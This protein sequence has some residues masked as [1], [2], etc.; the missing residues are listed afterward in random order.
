MITK[1]KN[2]SPNKATVRLSA[3]RTDDQP[4]GEFVK[5]GTTV[6]LSVDHSPEDIAKIQVE[7][8]RCISNGWLEEV[9]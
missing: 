4:G 2:I 1:I 5:H 9:Q 7:I 8:A 6:D 3:L